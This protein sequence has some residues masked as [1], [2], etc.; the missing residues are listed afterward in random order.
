MLLQAT[1]GDEGA[2]G[3]PGPGPGPPVEVGG[4]RRAGRRRGDTEP[5][6]TPYQF[7]PP[8]GAGPFRKPTAAGTG[9]GAGGAGGGAGGGG[10]PLTQPGQAREFQT[11]IFAPPVT[12]AP[13]KKSKFVNVNVGGGE[14]VSFVRLFFFLLVARARPRL[15]RIPLMIRSFRL[16]FQ[17]FVPHIFPLPTSRAFPLS[18]PFLIM[19][20][21]LTMLYLECRTR[22]HEFADDSGVPTHERGRPADMPAVWDGGT[23]QGRQVRRKVG[24]WAHGP[25]HRV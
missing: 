2:G 12:G 11:H 15:F 5:Q 9:A 17:S 20:L 23:L 25:R 21:T 22:A 16:W 7:H 18:L 1:T 6:G 3:T 19:I 13:Q 24:P 4:G 8:P 10:E 14:L